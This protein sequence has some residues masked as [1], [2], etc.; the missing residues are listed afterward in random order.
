MPGRPAWAAHLGCS[1]PLGCRGWLD[2]HA[3]AWRAVQLGKVLRDY[4]L[5]VQQLLPGL[6]A[7]DL[8]VQGALL[9][10][11]HTRRGSE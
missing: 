11:L 3:V 2:C 10:G 9:S 1:G 6:K 7:W 5:G 8:G 4:V